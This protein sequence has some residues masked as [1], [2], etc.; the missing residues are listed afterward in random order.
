MGLDIRFVVINLFQG[1]AEHI[2]DVIYR[3]HGQ[4]KN[5][6]KMHKSQLSSDRTSCRLP[7]RS[8]S[9]CIPPP[10]S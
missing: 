6:I 1:S 8:A 7:T 10:T 4:V 9:S 2:Y 5:L 3:V